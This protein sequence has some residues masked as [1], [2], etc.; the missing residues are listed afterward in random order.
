MIDVVTQFAIVEP[1]AER[2]DA[3]V[4]AH[5]HGHMLQSCGWGELKSRFGWQ[6]RRV[7]VAGPD[8]LLA[9]A[10]ILMRRRVGMAVAYVPRGPLFSGDPAAD[11]LLLRALERLARRARAVFL[12]LE[13]NVLEN[14]DDAMQLHSALLLH[15]MRMAEPL[16]PRSSIHLPLAPTPDRLLAAMSKGHRA[17]IK[18]AAREGVQVR[19]GETAADLDT[20]YGIMEATSARAA[21]GIHSK[22]YYAA[23]WDIFRADAAALLLIA[24]HGGAAVATALVAAWAGAGLYLYSGSTAGGLKNGAQHA[25]QW[26]ALQWA[27]ERGC[28]LYDFWGIPDALGRAAMTT[29]EAERERLEAEA[30]ND[31]LFGVYRFKKGFGGQIVRYLPAYDQVFMP[32]LY[33]LWQRRFGA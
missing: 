25:I 23:M 30:R 12:R 33:R 31:E 4:Q 18:R 15:G 10:Q 21:F 26:Q 7:A 27:R 1:D 8:G 29:D 16:Q 5:P 24:E 28:R 6:W 22:S 3:F 14:A 2:W 13:P 9:G 17:D 19:V 20:F 32:A 11:R